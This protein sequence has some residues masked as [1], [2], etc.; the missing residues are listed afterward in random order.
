[1]VEK[2]FRTPLG[3]PTLFFICSFPLFS[4]FC[5][6]YF[7]IWY[8]TNYISL[9][10]TEVW[11]GDNVREERFLVWLVLISCK[12]PDYVLTFELLGARDK[13][14]CR[15]IYTTALLCLEIQETWE[16]WV[17]S[18]GQ[19]DPLEKGMDTHSSILPS[20]IPWTEEPGGPTVHRVAKSRAQLSN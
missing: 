20:R 2:N 9:L 15:T 7:L 16:M 4:T 13:N 1:M 11:E 8:K 6:L 3:L 18:L 17:Q 12:T 10:E 14:T 5:T 19:E